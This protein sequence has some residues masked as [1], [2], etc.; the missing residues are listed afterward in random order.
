MTEETRRLQEWIRQLQAGI[1][2]P[3]IEL[4]EETVHIILDLSRDAAHQ[5]I[6]PA[7]PLTCF[8]VG[9]AVGRGA[10]LGATAAKATALALGQADDEGTDEDEEA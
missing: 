4:D 2:V 10:S 8:L 5:I 9:V 1:D 3:D 7:S 6:R